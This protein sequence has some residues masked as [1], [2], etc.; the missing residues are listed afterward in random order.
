[1]SLKNHEG[2]LLVDHHDSPGIPDEVAVKSGLPPGVG[3]KK[4]EAACFTCAHCEAV[5]VKD[6]KVTRESTKCVGCQHLLCRG[7]GYLY[8]LDRVCRNFKHRIEELRNS[9]EKKGTSEVLHSPLI[10]P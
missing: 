6:P 8:S 4:Y 1:M 9:A 5:V 10:I 7:C 2:Y 3:R